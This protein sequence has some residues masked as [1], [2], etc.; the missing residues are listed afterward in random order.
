MVIHCHSRPWYKQPFQ[1]NWG[2]GWLQFGYRICNY[3]RDDKS[4]IAINGVISG[5]CE[6]AVQCHWTPV[7]TS[8]WLSVSLCRP[9]SLLVS[10]SGLDVP[11][12]LYF[13]WFP[14]DLISFN[15]YLFWVGAVSDAGCL[16]GTKLT[17]KT[18]GILL[19]TPSLHS[20]P[21]PFL[22]MQLPDV[23][24]K[25]LLPHS[26]FQ[27]IVLSYIVWSCSLLVSPSLSRQKHV[28][29]L[30]ER[31]CGRNNRETGALFAQ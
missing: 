7:C 14:P 16:G 15:F 10:L 30:R 13:F 8:N 17:I 28:V 1:T 31:K 2:L 9:G 25:I 24:F 26:K 29:R 3:H 20:Q 27:L 18:Q 6:W 11:L 21:P 22:R 5:V 4:I 19:R 12:Y 23:C